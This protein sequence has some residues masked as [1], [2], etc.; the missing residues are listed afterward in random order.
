MKSFGD[1]I[2]EFSSNSTI[3]GLNF[4]SSTRILSFSSE[5]PSGTVGYVKITLEKD[6][7]FNPQGV[8]AFLDG[9]PV[10]YAI[11]STSQSWVLD[12]TY[13]HSVHNV[14]VNFNG[15]AEPE[16]F[17]TTIV[18]TASGASLAVVGIGLLVYFKKRK[19]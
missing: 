18:I 4:N 13:S 12:I 14:V 19:R 11:T 6:P 15:K 10:E 5:G 17:P 2:T 8:S 7:A 9:K 3:T 1:F 16:P